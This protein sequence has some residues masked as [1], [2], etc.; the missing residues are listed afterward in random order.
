[1]RHATSYA[2]RV[3]VAGSTVRGPMLEATR[4]HGNWLADPWLSTGMQAVAMGQ[5]RM[6]DAKIT[7]FGGNM[8]DCPRRI[9]FEQ[10]NVQP[11]FRLCTYPTVKLSMK[12]WYTAPSAVVG[13]AVVQVQ[14][15]LHP[16]STR[17]CHLGI[18]WW[19]HTKAGTQRSLAHVTVQLQWLPPARMVVRGEWWFPLHI[20][21]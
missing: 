8:I 15:P 9:S 10:S 7:G 3:S 16:Q 1:M 11:T 6:P 5:I 4:P 14:H 21:D 12:S 18:A 19:E 2:V 17:L 13:P 20:V